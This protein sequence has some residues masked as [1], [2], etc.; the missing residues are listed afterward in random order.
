[1]F[2]VHAMVSLGLKGVTQKVLKSVLGIKLSRSERHL[3]EFLCA[4]L[5]LL[6]YQ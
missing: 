5:A 1:V 2:D 6:Y 3:L 4:E